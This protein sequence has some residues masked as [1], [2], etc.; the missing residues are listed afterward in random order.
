MN[1]GVEG[2]SRSG[3]DSD[4]GFPARCLLLLVLYQDLAVAEAPSFS[5]RL[6][7]LTI[8][9]ATSSTSGSSTCPKTTAWRRGSCLSNHSIIALMAPVVDRRRRSSSFANAAPGTSSRNTVMLRLRFIRTLYVPRVFCLLHAFSCNYITFEYF[10]TS[11]SAV[12]GYRGRARRRLR[13]LLRAGH[14]PYLHKAK[15]SVT[16]SRSPAPSASS[17]CNSAL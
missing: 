7:R 14:V 11:F 4:I 10:C 13:R 17:G 1:Q 5:R 3:G 16:P 2:R 9:A 15:R 6:A 8:I 12:C